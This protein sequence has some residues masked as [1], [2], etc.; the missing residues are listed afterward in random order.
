M[1]F[2]GA[3][4]ILRQ[5]LTFWSVCVSN[6]VAE[7]SQL[8]ATSPLLNLHL[9]ALILCL[10]A[11]LACGRSCLWCGKVSFRLPF[12]CLC[13]KTVSGGIE[14]EISN[15]IGFLLLS[16]LESDFKGYI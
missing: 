16:N 9:T 15:S 8:T 2:E 5:E 13:V 1:R 3:V 4:L 14:V 12:A 10:N 6:R 7:W 11:T